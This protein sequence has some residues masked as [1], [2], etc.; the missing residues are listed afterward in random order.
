MRVL[1]ALLLTVLLAAA[2]WFAGLNVRTTVPL[3][4]PV[5]LVYPQ[6]PLLLL[7]F[8]ALV[9]GILIA[10]TAAIPDYLR[11]QAE[12]RRL[13]RQLRLLEAEVRSLR[14]LPITD[15]FDAPESR[16]GS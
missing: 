12:L 8:G 11:R 9:V 1:K 16:S 13:R 2:S 10:G 14:N 15:S 4:L 3:R 5:E 6:V 7:L